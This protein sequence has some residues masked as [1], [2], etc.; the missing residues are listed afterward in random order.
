MR[1]VMNDFDNRYHSPLTKKKAVKN[2]TA[3]AI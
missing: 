2:F 3:F 1:L